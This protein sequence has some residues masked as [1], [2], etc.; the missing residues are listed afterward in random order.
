M[1]GYTPDLPNRTRCLVV[2]PPSALRIRKNV[3]AGLLAP[4][5]RASGPIA[6]DNRVVFA[7]AHAAVVRAAAVALFARGFAG[8]EG[9]RTQDDHRTCG[10]S[11]T[12]PAPA[13]HLV[14]F[15]PH[16]AKYARGRRAE[17]GGRAVR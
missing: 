12:S 16:H 8:G 11:A 15:Y 10:R 14:R 7:R 13:H 17:K 6:T 3:P 1:R 2:L 4:A 5:E 9:Q